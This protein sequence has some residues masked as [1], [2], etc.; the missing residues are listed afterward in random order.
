M[1]PRVAEY[2]RPSTLAKD[3]DEDGDDSWGALL[4]RPSKPQASEQ[5]LPDEGSIPS[6]AS[7]SAIVM[8]T[9]P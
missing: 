3:E 8:E 6:A 1:K 4:A 7:I 2:S 9:W 5:A